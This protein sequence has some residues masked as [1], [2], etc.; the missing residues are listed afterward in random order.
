MNLISNWK[1]W[2]WKNKQTNKKQYEDIKIQVEKLTEEL[3]TSE[4]VISKIEH[5]STVDGSRG[6]SRKY[7]L[8][9]RAVSIGQLGGGH[10]SNDNQ[11][12]GLERERFF[13]N[14]LAGSVKDRNCLWFV[15]FSVNV[16]FRLNEILILLL[17]SLLNIFSSF[18]IH[19]SD[20][21]KKKP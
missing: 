16:L 6:G 7:K 19:V 10:L 2:F 4:E 8:E 3:E 21:K 13:T 9:F 11:T 12:D 17:S 1:L 18:Y 15:L 20:T 14:S 5:W